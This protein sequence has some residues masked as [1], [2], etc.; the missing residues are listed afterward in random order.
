VTPDKFRKLALALPDVEERSHFNH[1]DFRR[2][3]KIFATLGAPNAGWGMV[4]LDPQLQR[5]YMLPQPEVFKPAQGAWG[6]GGSTL[7]RL[8]DARVETVTEALQAA[9]KLA[10]PKPRKKRVR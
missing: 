7:V 8:K 10:E 4:K 6:L 5:V 3:G 1:P 2:S 9:W